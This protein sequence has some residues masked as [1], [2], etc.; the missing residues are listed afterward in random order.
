M[1]KSLRLMFG[2]VLLG[3]SSLV[4]AAWPDRPISLVVPFPPGGSTDIV[5]RLLGKELSDRLGVTVMVENRP[6]A[7]GNVGSRYVVNS[8]ADGY[9]LL[10]ATTAQTIGAAIYKNPGYDV[11]KD[12][13]AISGI[14]DGPLLLMTRPDLGVTNMQELLELSKRTPEGFTIG[15]AGNGGSPHMAAEILGLATGMKLVHVPFQGAAPAMNA[16]IGGQVDLGFDLIL[17]ARPFVEEKRV[18]A[19]GMATLERY[20]LYPQLPTLAEQSPDKLGSFNE[21]AWNV[22]LAPKGTPADIVEK[23]NAH[24]K[25]ILS[26]E[27]VR[28]KLAEMSNVPIWKTPQETQAFIEEDVEKWKRVV[29]EAN[30]EKL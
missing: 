22:L 21:S 14:N 19:I 24:M 10:V 20:P 2:G 30:L 25:D 13:E 5:G 23:L 18:Q 8:K 29:R 12:F 27:Q 15:N 6:G 26:S 16:L 17:G 11:I 1:K 9:T 3:I 4:Q 7:A 28:A